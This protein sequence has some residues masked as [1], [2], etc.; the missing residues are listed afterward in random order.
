MKSVRAAIAHFLLFS[1]VA[2][3]PYGR[4]CS[5]ERLGVLVNTHQDCDI[6]FQSKGRQI[7]R[8]AGRSGERSHVDDVFTLE[9]SQL[10]LGT[11]RRRAPPVNVR[12]GRDARNPVAIRLYNF[13]QVLPFCHWSIYP[14]VASKNRHC[15]GEPLIVVGGCGSLHLYLQVYRCVEHS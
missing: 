10:E 3:V 4:A 9:L 11:R 8:N 1:A 7:C 6:T 12:S 13:K 5:Q 15:N 2:R 14:V